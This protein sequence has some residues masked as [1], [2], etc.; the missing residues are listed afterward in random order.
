MTKT[1]I[2]KRTREEAIEVCLLT[3]DGDAED[4]GAS[5]AAESLAACVVGEVWN[6]TRHRLS[7]DEDYLEAAALLRGD[8]EHL[9][10]SPGDAV[11]LRP[12]R[13]P[14]H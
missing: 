4:F 3:A 11:Y 13:G 5:S 14:N 8:D 6:V 10:W 9:P 12:H 7:V 1:K 2:S